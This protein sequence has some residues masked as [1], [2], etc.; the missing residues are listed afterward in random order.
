[1]KENHQH[2][3][4]IYLAYNLNKVNKKI[5]TLKHGMLARGDRAIDD[6][7]KNISALNDEWKD[8]SV[9]EKIRYLGKADSNLGL[10]M[11][12][13]SGDDSFFFL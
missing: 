4:N 5:K 9:T 1:M 11:E 12:L 2:I 8:K 6:A 13:M 10:A 7:V 3:S